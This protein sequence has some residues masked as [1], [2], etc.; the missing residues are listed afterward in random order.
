MTK[1][2]SEQRTHNYLKQIKGSFIFKGLA[3]VASLVSI[4]LMI[5]YLGQEQYGIW[6][7]LLSVMSWVVFFD[8][9]IGNG[10][11]NKV[12]EALANNNTVE[13]SSYISSGYTLIGLISL[14]LFII[15]ATATFYIPWR[16]VFNTT[17]IDEATLRNTVFVSAF[18][19]TLNFWI[20]LINQVLNAV[21]KTSVIV[22]GQFISNTVALSF[23]FT[24]TQLMYPSL[25]YLALAYGTSLIISN[26]TL[27]LWFYNKRRELLPKL[28][29]NSQHIRPIMSLGL[30]FFIIQ[31]ACLVIFTTDK[32]LI[33]QFFGSQ[34]VTQYD[35]VFKLFGIITLVY[36]LI[37]APLW[38]SYT[39]AYHREDFSWVKR[40]LTK[41]LQIFGV[42]FLCVVI[43]IPL[44]KPTILLW[45]GNDLQI[46][47][48]LIISMGGF[49]LLST[50]NNIFGSILGGINKIRLG[51]F[52]T[53][54]TAAVNIPLCYLF[55]I[56]LNFGIAGI[57]LGTIA[58]IGISAIIS[59]LQVY[60]FIY[61]KQNNKF[62]SGLLR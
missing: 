5:R 48:S 37:S 15:A 43:M 6:S 22:F 4:P 59:P 47:I 33:T 3:V 49:V 29:L 19:I 14:C 9:G 18:F 13:A 46:P 41:Q 24:L 2:V 54:V 40:I 39:D 17:N 26:V 55:A 42:I 35:V 16:T 34:Y 62:L 23:V 38:S 28:T 58:S 8:L 50:W 32:M 57:I 12:A 30:Q 1:T 52:Y 60:Y 10:L 25:Y 20:S 36:S 53:I 11:R 27:T 21:Q 61:T 51:S 56:K 31:L 45:I 7:T 44:A